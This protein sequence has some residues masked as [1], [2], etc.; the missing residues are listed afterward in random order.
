M[1]SEATPTWEASGHAKSGKPWSPH[2]DS[3]A[4]VAQSHLLVLRC[5]KSPFGEV[6]ARL[7]RCS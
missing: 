1:T 5:A 6:S 2:M 4:L 7:A 3:R